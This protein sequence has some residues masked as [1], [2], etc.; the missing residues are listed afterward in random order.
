MVA[1]QHRF[2]IVSI[3]GFKDC[4]SIS[5]QIESETYTRSNPVIGINIAGNPFNL[6]PIPAKTDASTDIQSFHYL[7]GILGKG[8]QPGVI[9]V[10]I[11]TVILIGLNRDNHSNQSTERGHPAL[12]LHRYSH[13]GS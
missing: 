9:G 1:G 13:N 4:C 5:Q 2:G 12:R 6:A 7:P 10:G 11:I 8:F 3:M